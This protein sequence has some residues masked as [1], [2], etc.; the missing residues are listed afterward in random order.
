MKLSDKDF[1]TLFGAALETTDY[2]TYIAEWSTS[3]IFFP[4]PDAEGPGFD[5]IAETLDNVWNTAHISIREIRARAG[6]SQAA[7]ALRFCIPRR[8][9]EDW[10]AGR[11]T[12]P[13]YVR[14]LLAE[15]PRI[16]NI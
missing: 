10:E 15:S 4:D 11:R 1:Y 14:L 2:D 9:I 8:T 16:A 13:D 3:D 12:P 7:F 5:D 6:L